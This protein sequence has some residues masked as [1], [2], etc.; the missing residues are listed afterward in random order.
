MGKVDDYRGFAAAFLDLAK[1]TADRADKTRLFLMAEAWLNL[2]DRAARLVTGPI[3]GIAEHPLV[4]RTLG[5]AR[6]DAE[7]PD[8][9][10]PDAEQTIPGLF[11]S[12]EL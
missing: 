7:L 8:A 3:R 6:P 2:A 10:L 12:T 1:G 9:E 5:P 11:R 4:R